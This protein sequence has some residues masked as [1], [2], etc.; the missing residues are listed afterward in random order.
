MLIHWIWLSQLTG[1]TT[2]QKLSLLQRFRDPEEIFNAQRV[3]LTEG[4]EMSEKALAALSDKNLVQARKILDDCAEKSI[5]ILTY[6]DGAYPSK[7]KNIHNPPLVLYYKGCLPDWEHR[8]A[9][10]MI[11]TR[12]ASPYGLQIAEKLGNQIAGCG[13]LVVSGGA[14]GIDTQ[15]LMGALRTGKKVVAV[16]GCGADMIY[17]AKNK[18]LF[19]Q[20]EKQGC[21]LTEFCPGT[22]PSSWNFPHR[23]RIIS[24]LSSGVVIVEAPERSGALNTASH[25]ADQ[26]R[27][28]FVV[29]GNINNPN[30][31]GSNRLLR[32]R[33]LAVFTGWDVVSEYESLYPGTV[34]RYEGAAESPAV[35]QMAA[36]PGLKPIQNQKAD[37]NSI[38]NPEKSKYSVEEN[39]QLN[40]TA[41][42]QAVL[43]FVTKQPVSVDEVIAAAQLPAG[44]V[45]SVL[46]MLA[47]KGAVKNHP[48]KCVSLK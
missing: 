20:I 21:L 11:G 43:R 27:D 42:E 37:K 40:L 14:D 48:G 25:A 24:G 15:A 39:V 6:G 7:L 16:F 28:I 26:G 44:K 3:A 36:H 2:A 30:C 38:D 4:V 10:G 23:N 32:E 12:K 19:A 35:A 9:I 1:I 47:M 46:T 33:A 8:P 34:S 41:E 17:P 5:S 31:A 13:A 29:P 45:L 22:P 18:Q